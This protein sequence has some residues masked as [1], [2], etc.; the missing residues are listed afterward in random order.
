M[1]ETINIDLQS[2][3]ESHTLP[4][5]VIDKDCRVV[6][7]NRAY[8]QIYGHEGGRVLGKRCF[9]ITHGNM[10]ACPE[11]REDCPH[12][13][14]YQTGK[15]HTCLHVRHDEHHRKHRVRVTGF[16][17]QGTD[18]EL[19]MGETVEEIAAP[20]ERRINGIRMVGETPVFLACLEQLNLAAA[21]DTS[22]LVLGET[23]TGKGLAARYIHNNSSRAGKPFQTLDCT[24]FTEPLFEA[25]VFGHEKGA[26]TGSV[27][28]KPGLFEQADG[29]TLFLDEIGDMSAPLQA[30]L[31]RLVETGEFRRVGGRKDLRADVR[32]ICATN[33]N[34]C[35]AVVAE[36]FRED[37]YYRVACIS[38]RIPSLRE[39][40]EDIPVLACAL[41]D[42]I[43]RLFQKRLRLTDGALDQLKK[44]DYPGNARELANI[45]STAVAEAANGQ[46]N[47]RSIANVLQ[48]FDKSPAFGSQVEESQQPLPSASLSP[49]AATLSELEVQHIAELLRQYSGNRKQVAAALGISER[50]LYRKLTRYQLR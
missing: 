33:R 6:A 32:I 45:L 44:Y 42:R 38:I 22:V 24:V 15:V 16:P 41:L 25:E 18:G 14:V 3:M 50:T 10:L 1:K 29:G 13:H 34:L 30:K 21:A 46:I 48:R 43:G 47:A 27:G 5:L 28:E 26:F 20:E 2:W 12:A 37:L 17:L 23:G 36:R 40:R 11:S 19:F 9:E 49:A 7:V 31:L 35:D 39:R 4:F 8:E